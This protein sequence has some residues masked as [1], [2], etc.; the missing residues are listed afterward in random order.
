MKPDVE[1]LRMFVCPMYFHVSKDKRNNLE[2]TGKKDMFVGYCNS[3]RAFIIYVYGPRN[4]DFSKDVTF[5]EDVAPIKARDIPPPPPIEKKD[6]NMD[7][8]DGTF[9]LE[10]EKEVDDPMEPMDHLDPPTKKILLWLRIH[11]RMLKYMSFQ[12]KQESMSIPG[13]CC[14]YELH[15]T[16]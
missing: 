6:D 2:A 1:H 12:R 9:V 14:G 13:V 16:G 7:L 10:K 8:L 15:D 4:I 11:Y 5:D 3:S